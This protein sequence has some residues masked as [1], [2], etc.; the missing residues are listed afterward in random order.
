MIVMT[1]DAQNLSSPKNAGRPDA[2]DQMFTQTHLDFF[3]R[4]AQG[5]GRTNT[6]PA[7]KVT[8]PIL[9]CENKVASGS[10]L[11]HICQQ[12]GLTLSPIRPRIDEAIGLVMPQTPVLL[13]LENADGPALA[14]IH[15]G[16][17]MTVRIDVLSHCEISNYVVSNVRAKE[18]LAGWRLKAAHRVT[19]M[20]DAGR[21][22]PSSYEAPTAFRRLRLLLAPDRS[23]IIIV[24][25]FAVGLGFLTLATPIAVQTLVNFVA[26][27]GLMQPLIVVGILLL[28]FM[29]FAG[30]IRVFKFYVVEILQRRVF[31]RVVS[32]LSIRLPRVRFDSYDR[33]YSPELVNRFFDVMTV[34]KA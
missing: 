20:G 16:D 23:E 6:P 33:D 34:Q 17:A 15:N 25:G 14:A 13:E 31:T 22:K 21:A 8:R 28:F 3:E 24:I 9:Q 29:A 27:G 30:A 2:E 18:R 19:S 11:I 10:Q 32:D 1:Q 12:F 26:F 5:T 7:A 4:L